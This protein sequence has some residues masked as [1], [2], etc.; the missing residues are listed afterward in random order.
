MWAN[1]ETNIYL[2]A[3]SEKKK[4]KKPYCSWLQTFKLLSWVRNRV[5]GLLREYTVLLA[6]PKLTKEYGFSKYGS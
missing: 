6:Y 4:K 5:L 2:L 1:T 3:F